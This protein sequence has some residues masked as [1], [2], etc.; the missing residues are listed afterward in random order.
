MTCFSWNGSELK[1]HR[2][3]A[4]LTQAQLARLVGRSHASVTHYEANFSVP[5]VQVLLR[6]SE[7]LQVEPGALFTQ[8]EQE[9]VST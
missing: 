2:L 6:L 5:P 7:A 9:L 8:E 3:A 1:R 4:G